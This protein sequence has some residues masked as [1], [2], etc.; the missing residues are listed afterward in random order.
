MVMDFI[1]TNYRK[2]SDKFMDMYQKRKMR[3]EN[4][5]SNNQESFT[6]VGINWYKPTLINFQANLDFI[7]FSI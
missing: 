2:G 5:K 4:K 6:S 7:R 1:T 3:A